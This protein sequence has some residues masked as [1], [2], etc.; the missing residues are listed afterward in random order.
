M[1]NVKFW[2]LFSNTWNYLIVSSGSLKKCIYQM[3]LQTIYIFI[4][5]YKQDLAL[6][7]LQ[8]LICNKTQP[9]QILYI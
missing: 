3:C 7:N 5:M 1:T 9:S 2:Q 8:W 4:Y 6:K